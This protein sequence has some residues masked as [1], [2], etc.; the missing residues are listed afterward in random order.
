MWQLK[1]GSFTTVFWP[2]RT[3]RKSQFR[4]GMF[5]AWKWIAWIP[6][7]DFLIVAD[8][9]CAATG[10]PALTRKGSILFCLRICREVF[11][12]MTTPTPCLHYSSHPNLLWRERE[13]C[14]FMV[15]S[16]LRAMS[17]I[18]LFNSPTYGN[19]YEFAYINFFCFSF[20]LFVLVKWK[21]HGGNGGVFTTLAKNAN[22]RLER[23]CVP[24]A[25]QIPPFVLFVFPIKLPN[26]RQ[27]EAKIWSFR[28]FL[29]RIVFSANSLWLADSFA[30]GIHSAITVCESTWV[31]NNIV[32]RQRG[33]TKTKTNILRNWLD[34]FLWK[35]WLC[36]EI[37]TQHNGHTYSILHRLCHVKLWFNI[38]S[39]TNPIKQ[40]RI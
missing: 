30:Y 29:G 14:I 11:G 7:W 31:T 6:Y 17:P 37:T 26:A 16:C 20:A 32:T 13:R 25:Y 10:R 35:R 21:W 8:A 9:A 22:N 1:F 19:G 2:M 28:S 24:G 23:N 33:Q 39:E 15:W 34:S 4:H 18:S 12:Q 27:N 5:W 36:T 3:F 40:K 38:Q